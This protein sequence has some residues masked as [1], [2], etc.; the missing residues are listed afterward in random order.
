MSGLKW[1]V[2]VVALAGLL[3]PAVGNVSAE[4]ADIDDTWFF[5]QPD[6][7]GWH[8]IKFADRAG[9]EDA[10]SHLKRLETYHG[11]PCASTTEGRCADTP[12][13]VFNAVIPVC[14]DAADVNCLV[15]F[16]TVDDVEKRTPATFTRAV[17]TSGLSDFAAERAVDLPRGA[18]GQLWQLASASHAAGDQY[19]T[20]VRVTG[21]RTSAGKFVHSALDIGLY[22]TKSTYVECD[23]DCVNGLGYNEV[24]K[25]WEYNKGPGDGAQFGRTCVAFGEA[26]VNS[27]LGTCLERKAI[28]TDKRFYVTVRLSQTPVG[29]LHGRLSSPEVSVNKTDNGV[30]TIDVVGRAIPVPVVVKG[31]DWS[32]LPASLQAV[33]AK[34]SWPGSR[35]AGGTDMSRQYV[36]VTDP[37]RRNILFL[38]SASGKPGIEELQAWIP[39]VGDK[40][41]ANVTTWGVRTLS[42]TEMSGAAT[43]ITNEK[44]V[45]GIVTTNATQYSAGPPTFV[46]A[47]GTLDYQVAAPHLTSGGRVLGGDYN[48]VMK[49]S[50]ARCI[51]GFTNAPVSMSIS[52]TD[53]G[54][55]TKTA[56]TSVSEAGGWLKLSASGFTF[57]SP[58]V[59]AKIT[60]VTPPDVAVGAIR[61]AKSLATR[62]KLKMSK[63]SRVSLNVLKASTKVCAVQGSR[64]RAKAAGS[65]RVTV[66]VTTG[67]KKSSRTLT[68]TVG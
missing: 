21:S 13:Q 39:L 18:T 67:R 52:V 25:S 50:V 1:S 31:M 27:K 28:P 55:E 66:T 46:R 51:Y 54:G 47:T 44:G 49:S 29:W 3:V 14:V 30:T 58:T 17:P 45:A 40:A 63:T 19:Y 42:K 6:T 36:T 15:G 53:T 4:S 22:A 5:E 37:P 8:G 2:L 24:M 43:C 7:A 33:Y 10:F 59:K 56:V 16:G 64:L 20:R 48:L 23:R 12:E 68:L 34:S 65:C 26:E 61:T 38:P 60:Q 32:E 62:A 57:S 41:S 9:P 11:K 35:E